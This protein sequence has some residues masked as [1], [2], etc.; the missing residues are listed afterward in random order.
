MLLRKVVHHARTTFQQ[1][2]EANNRLFKQ[3]VMKMVL[4]DFKELKY[5]RV[6]TEQKFLSSCPPLQFGFLCTI[7]NERDQCI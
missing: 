3:N 1:V 7:E 4:I 6:E 5:V 2:L